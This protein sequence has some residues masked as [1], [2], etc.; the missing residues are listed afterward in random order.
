[1]FPRK[2][3]AGLALAALAASAM[4]VARAQNSSSSPELDQLLDDDGRVWTFT[5]NDFAPS[6][7]SNGFRWT[8]VVTKDVA[9][10]TDTQLT[11]IGLRVWEALARFESGTLRVWTV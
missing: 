11:F 7:S 2:Q 6:Q 8:S 1:M 4:P 3:I 9:R 10:S 5:A